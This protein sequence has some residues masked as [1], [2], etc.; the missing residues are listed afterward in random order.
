MG[1]TTTKHIQDNLKKEKKGKFSSFH[2]LKANRLSTAAK[3]ETKENELW[4]DDAV[5]LELFFASLKH[6]LGVLY[7]F[8]MK[9]LV[10]CV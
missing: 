8:T 9:R 6:R 4:R 2:N 10:F 3:E 5:I 7:L 1:R